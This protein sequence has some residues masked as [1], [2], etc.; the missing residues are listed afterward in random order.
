MSDIQAELPYGWSDEAWVIA[1]IEDRIAWQYLNVQ[2]FLDR[3]KADDDGT[4]VDPLRVQLHDKGIADM[5][6]AESATLNLLYVL[7]SRIEN[8]D[9]GA[10]D[11]W[12]QVHN[13]WGLDGIAPLTGFDETDY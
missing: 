8:S 5:V 3:Q 13:G 2:A 10:V 6:R 12:V 11:D 7:R 1:E 4:D 9:P